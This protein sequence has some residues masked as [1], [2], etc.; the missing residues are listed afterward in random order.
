VW[1][2][3]I[4]QLEAQL[5]QLQRLAAQERFHLDRFN[6]MRRDE[7]ATSQQQ[8]Q[9]LE[10]SYN[11]MMGRVSHLQSS[12]RLLQEEIRQLQCGES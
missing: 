3:Y 2:H 12:Y 6:R 9:Q 5:N 10:H 11:D 1:R 4:Q 7:Q 8:I